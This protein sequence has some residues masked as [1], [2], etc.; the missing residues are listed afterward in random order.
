M[1]EPTNGALNAIGTACPLGTVLPTQT[2]Q[3][4]GTIAHKVAKAIG[5]T[6][7]PTPNPKVRI[8]PMTVPT[9]GALSA[10]GTV[11]PH[12]TVIVTQTIMLTRTIAHK[13]VKAIGL[14][15]LPTPEFIP[16]T[17]PPN[18]A[19]SAVGTACLCDR[20]IADYPADERAILH[21]GYAPSLRLSAP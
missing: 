3:L 12:E 7:L 9:N 5:L 2:I 17:E 20:S 19:L 18:G 8:I 6:H 4:T 13:T 21:G 10:V 14:T 16:E 1:T 15:H 11:C